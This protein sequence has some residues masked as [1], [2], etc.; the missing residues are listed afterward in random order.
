[1]VFTKSTR[2][3]CPSPLRN[4]LKAS[5]RSDAQTASR[6]AAEF[7]QRREQAVAFV[8]QLSGAGLLSDISEGQFQDSLRDG[9]LLLQMLNK[10]LLESH[11]DT[12]KV[13]QVVSESNPEAHAAYQSM[14][15]ISKFLM[16]VKA[17]NPELK[18][19]EASDFEEKVR[20]QASSYNLNMRT[21]LDHSIRASN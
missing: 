20:P 1:M 15:N 17:M 19:F 10:I 11:Q 5:M 8:N 3:W 7:A 12:V 21:C 4:S 13:V 9:V 2:T 18:L 6:K 16:R 14:E